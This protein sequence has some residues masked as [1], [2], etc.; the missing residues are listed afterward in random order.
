[1]VQMFWDITE[2]ENGE[3]LAPHFDKS[4]ESHS[5]VPFLFIPTSTAP[6]LTYLVTATI[7]LCNQVMLR[8]QWKSYEKLEITIAYQKFWVNRGGHHGYSDIAF[9]NSFRI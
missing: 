2:P 4:L 5:P 6:V 7:E 8:I 9:K 3:R 1:M